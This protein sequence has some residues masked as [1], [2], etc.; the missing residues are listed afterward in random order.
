MLASGGGY[1]ALKAAEVVA[2]AAFCSGSAPR[3]A[4]AGSV[5]LSLQRCFAPAAVASWLTILRL[6]RARTASVVRACEW[7]FTVKQRQRRSL[8]R[9]EEASAL[10]QDPGQTKIRRKLLSQTWLIGESPTSTVS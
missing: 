5:S 1:Y 2:V 8:R 6:W 9:T 3:R 4:A 7:S 10:P